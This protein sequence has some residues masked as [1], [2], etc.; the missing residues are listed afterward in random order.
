LT[1]LCN[2]TKSGKHIKL[3]V[4]LPIALV[5]TTTLK[6]KTIMMKTVQ[7][8]RITKVMTLL[9]QEQKQEKM[10]IYQGSNYRQLLGSGT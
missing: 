8:R 5:G 2:I 9:M 7:M 10:T 1:L 3:N 4:I 6:V